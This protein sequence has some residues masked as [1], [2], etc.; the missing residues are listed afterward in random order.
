MTVGIAF[1]HKKPG[2]LTFLIQKPSSLF[3][4]NFFYIC[5]AS[6]KQIFSLENFPNT[7]ILKETSF[8]CFF[9]SFGQR[10]FLFFRVDCWSKIMSRCFTNDD[11]TPFP[12]HA[13]S[14]RANSIKYFTFINFHFYK[15]SSV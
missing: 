5:L 14:I 7:Y 15:F 13:S 1:S 12:L 8:C 11:L 3:N 4:I 10:L 2:K 6:S 9:S